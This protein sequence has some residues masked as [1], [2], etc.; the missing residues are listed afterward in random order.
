M[1]GAA[2]E[3]KSQTRSARSRRSC[4]PSSEALQ[5]VGDQ[6]AREVAREAID[7]RRALVEETRDFAADLI[8]L[9]EHVVGI[10]KQGL[11]MFID[12]LDAKVQLNDRARLASRLGIESQRIDIRGKQCALQNCIGC[13]VVGWNHFV[14][15]P[16][17][18]LADNG[19][20]QHLFG[21]VAVSLVSEN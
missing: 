5:D 21:L 7:C 19:L 15:T 16:T 2:C 1:Q 3:Q 9:A 8:L 6:C 12:E 11:A 20:R 14:R 13:A 10:L 17:R 18:E 4:G